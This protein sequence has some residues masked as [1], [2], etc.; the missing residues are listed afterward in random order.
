MGDGLAIDF[1]A[2][3]GRNHA[4]RRLDS[5]GYDGFVQEK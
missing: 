1:L 2:L 3:G 4:L 5:A